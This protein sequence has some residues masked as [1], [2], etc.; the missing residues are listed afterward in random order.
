MSLLDQG[1]GEESIVSYLVKQN[2][3]INAV[4]MYGQTPLHYAAMRGNEIAC[5]DLLAFK[6]TIDISVS[7]GKE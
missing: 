2:A 5:R 7:A 1:D 6:D 4:D 3:N